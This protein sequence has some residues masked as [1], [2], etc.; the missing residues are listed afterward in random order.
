MPKKRLNFFRNGDLLKVKQEHVCEIAQGQKRVKGVLKAG[1]TVVFMGA[2]RTPS[3][4]W[5]TDCNGDYKLMELV[6]VKMI[7]QGQIVVMTVPDHMVYKF[8]KLVQ[9]R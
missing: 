1:S 3:L 4:D 8:L 9:K 7:D 5:D 2:K 6:G